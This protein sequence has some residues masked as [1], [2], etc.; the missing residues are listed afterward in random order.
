MLR[1]SNIETI[2]DK[3]NIADTIKTPS[4]II[5][6]SIS[7]KTIINNID[8]NVKA[9]INWYEKPK[10]KYVSANSNPD[11]NSYNG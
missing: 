11:I 10:D 1:I 6:Y 5:I 3:N 7:L 4:D 8:T 2:T 9:I